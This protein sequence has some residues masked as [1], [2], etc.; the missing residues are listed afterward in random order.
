MTP[1]DLIEILAIIDKLKIEN[2]PYITRQEKELWKQFVDEL[3]KRAKA[4][5]SQQGM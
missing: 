4:S 1:T 3:K 5:L 2:N